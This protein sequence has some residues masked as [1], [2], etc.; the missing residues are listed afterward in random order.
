MRTTRLRANILLAAA[1]W[2]IWVWAT[3][4]WNIL[5]DQHPLGFKVVHSALAAVSV[6][7]GIAIGVIGW[8][9]H[10]EAGRT[11]GPSSTTSPRSRV[12]A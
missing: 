5:S 8:R 1:A 2:T 6:A 10:R 12:G 3:R 11:A 4:I 7:F 9:L